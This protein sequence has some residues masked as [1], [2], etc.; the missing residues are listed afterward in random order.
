MTK[1][2]EISRRVMELVANGMDV[3]EALK[4]VCGVDAVESMIGELYDTLRA[5]K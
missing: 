2:Q 5:A 3:I 1:N 4:N